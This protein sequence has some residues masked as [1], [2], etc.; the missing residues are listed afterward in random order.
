LF[1]DYIEIGRASEEEKNDKLDFYI[2]NKEGNYQKIFIY[3]L[4]EEDLGNQIINKR[5]EQL[6]TIDEIENE[7][8]DNIYYKENNNDF[9]KINKEKIYI[10]KEKDLENKILYYKTA[11][12]KYIPY[13]NTISP[14][15][16]QK[17]L[18]I[19]ENQKYIKF[20]DLIS[21]N[22]LHMSS[23]Q[24]AFSIR[25]IIDN[26]MVIISNSPFHHPK[27]ENIIG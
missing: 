21:I 3:F 9:I 8:K 27:Q 13:N 26:I 18:Y 22:I 23:K 11:D 10:K 19:K 12:E 6:T 15:I 20:S 14:E 16:K 25:K 4:I 7:N 5:Y 1:I 17:T 2:Q 24:M